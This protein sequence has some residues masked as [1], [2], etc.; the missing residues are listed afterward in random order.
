[1][2]TR[3]KYRQG[4]DSMELYAFRTIKIKKVRDRIKHSL[5]LNPKD[6]GNY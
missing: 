6:K 2:S 1:M 4:E 5:L 3:S